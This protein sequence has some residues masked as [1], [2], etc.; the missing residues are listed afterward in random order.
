VEESSHPLPK[1]PESLCQNPGLVYLQSH[2]VNSALPWQDASFTPEQVNGV[3]TGIPELLITAPG[4][5]ALFRLAQPVHI[6]SPRS[7]FD[8]K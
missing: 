5:A 6:T 2:Q 7:L 1:V 4:H 3:L 8:Q